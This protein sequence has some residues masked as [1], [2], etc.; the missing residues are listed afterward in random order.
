MARGARSKKTIRRPALAEWLPAALVLGSLAALIVLE[1]RRP[2]RRRVEP[3]N[4]RD[5][6]NLALAATAGIALRIV[7][8]P[9]V[10]PLAE[11]VARRRWGLLQWRKLPVAVEAALALAL[12]DYT[13]Y[14]WHVLLHRWPLL[15]RCHLVHHVDLDLSASTAIRFHFAEMVLS[16]PWRAAQIVL[17]GV[18]LP[19][20]KAWQTATLVEVLFQHSDLRLPLRVERGL[21]FLVVTPRMHGIH[22]SSVREET[23]SNW[24]SGLTVWDWLHGTLRLDVPQ[25][26]IAIGTAGYRDP[27]ELALPAL[28]A[29]PF[30]K[31][32]PAWLPPGGRVVAQRNPPPLRPPN[33]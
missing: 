8:K 5:L 24:S 12:M 3:R 14:L 17:L 19:I 18:R 30:G 27:R 15:W 25:R 13:L 21:Q 31:A 23:D 1:R 9:V 2:L 22:H 29:M 16:M 11:F 28:L 6:R 20:L 32:R 33:R 7:E 26:A 4:T 10:E